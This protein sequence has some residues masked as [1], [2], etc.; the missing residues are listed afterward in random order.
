MADNMKKIT[1]QSA[2][3]ILHMGETIVSD[4]VELLNEP[5]RI[6]HNQD[7]IEHLL[8]LAAEEQNL[9]DE[10]ILTIAYHDIIYYPQSKRNEELSAVVYQHMDLLPNRDVIDAI[11]ASK[12]HCDPANSSLPSWALDFLDYDLEGLANNFRENGRKIYYEFKPF[13]ST[14]EFIAGRGAFYEKMLS[15]E[16]IF[17]NHPEWEDKA[18][19]NIKNDLYWLNKMSGPDYI[20]NLT[21]EGF[22]V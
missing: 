12:D 3:D 17:W 16:R 7:H 1:L 6:Y 4:I 19:I 13:C 5:H 8:G 11:H 18:R 20:R 10:M 9:F 15:N 21:A 22:T 2:L 14:K